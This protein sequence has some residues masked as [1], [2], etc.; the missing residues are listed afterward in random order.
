M[1][2]FPKLRALTW[3]TSKTRPA[4]YLQ[5]RCIG[6]AATLPVQPFGGSIPETPRSLRTP[7]APPGPVI[8][9]DVS[10]YPQ[11]TN[12]DLKH[13]PVHGVL[14][15]LPDMCGSKFLAP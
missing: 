7:P 13:S 3:E 12:G 9:D 5:T 10:S 15:G 1:T 4:P 6:A 8:S 14:A 2:P 11:H